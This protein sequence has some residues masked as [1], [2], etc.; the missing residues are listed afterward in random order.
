MTIKEVSVEYDALNSKNVFTNGDTINGRII[1]QA[2]KDS[3]IR[4]LILIATGA[5][6]VSWSDGD[7]S[8][9]SQQEEYYGIK[10]YIMRES[11]DGMYKTVHPQ[12][13]IQY[14]TVRAIV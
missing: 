7:D 14:V 8:S 6:H 4:S 9:F 13:G 5:A 10:H 3:P 2:S 1:V 11:E 12:P